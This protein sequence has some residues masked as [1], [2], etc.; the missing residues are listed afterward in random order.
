VIERNPDH[1]SRNVIK[2]IVEAVEPQGATTILQIN[3]G[4]EKKIIAQIN[5]QWGREA[6][7]T[8]TLTV[9]SELIHVFDPKTEQ[10]CG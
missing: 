6:G 3:I 5:E 9:A 1:A 7:E 10:A 2:G 8:L 4:Q